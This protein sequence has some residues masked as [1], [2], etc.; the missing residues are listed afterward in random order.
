MATPK[1]DRIAIEFIKKIPDEFQTDFTAG[2]GEMPA[3]YVLDTADKISDYV[4]R[5][6]HTYFN[7]TWNAIRQKVTDRQEQRMEFAKIFPEMIPKTAEFELP[8][9]IGMD[10]KYRD[11]YDVFTGYLTSTNRMIRFWENDKLALVQTSK[12]LRYTPTEKNPVIIKTENNK[13]IVLEIF[14]DSLNGE[15]AIIN[16]IKFPVDPS[17]GEYLEQDGSIDVPFNETRI[18]DI[19]NIAFELYLQDTQQTT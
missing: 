5:A 14:P 11:F 4:N 7:S 8:L 15:S 16:Y 2:S 19:V 17:T 18:P 10:D 3:A 6:L 9:I 1:F 12:I 13:L